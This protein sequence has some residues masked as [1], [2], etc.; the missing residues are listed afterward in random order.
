MNQSRGVVERGLTVDRGGPNQLRSRYGNPLP[1][2]MPAT[3]RVLRLRLRL[4]LALAL[5]QLD[6]GIPSPRHGREISQQERMLRA[7][8]LDRGAWLFG[9]A[10]EIQPETAREI[11]PRGIATPCVLRAPVTGSGCGIMACGLPIAPAFWTLLCLVQT[12]E[13][14][15]ELAPL[16]IL[17]ESLRHVMPLLHE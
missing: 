7:Q 15:E 17:G 13:R 1:P 14:A 11:Q 6:Q 8:C 2:S 3:A 10:L 4:R 5:L 12:S 16:G 9:F